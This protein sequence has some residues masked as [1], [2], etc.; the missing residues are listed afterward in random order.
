[1]ATLT[2]TQ[3]LGIVYSLKEGDDDGWDVTS[4]EYLSGRKYCNAAIARWEYYDNTKWREL[5]TTLTAAAD[6]DK[7]T[8]GTNVYDCPTNFRFPS[9]WVRINDV[10]YEVVT[11]NR[12]AELSDSDAYFCY[13]SG[14]DKDGHKLNINPRIAL[15]TGDTIE[16]EYYKS[17]STF[18]TTTST[19]EMSNPYFIVNS[20]LSQFIKLDGEDNIQ[21]LQQADEFLE[22]MKIDN[23]SGFFG[24]PDPLNETISNNSGFG[25]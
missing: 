15:G 12:L 17:A 6:G 25:E 16:Y 2:E 23:E 18:T 5:W 8:D 9:S 24:V 4:E 21:E 7:T 3:I 11:P 10:H 13:F 1:M 19:T 20:V 22:Q 14:S